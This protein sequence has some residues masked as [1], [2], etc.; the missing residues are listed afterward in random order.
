M[1]TNE[2]R[3]HASRRRLPLY[4]RIFR[5]R[6]AARRKPATAG[7]RDGPVAA[8]TKRAD[9]GQQVGQHVGRNQTLAAVTCMLAYLGRYVLTIYAFMR[10]R[11]YS[12]VDLS[13]VDVS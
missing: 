8:I 5:L 12:H 4:P 13:R 11:K 6:A 9:C 3:F 10:T 7:Q 1:R 2:T